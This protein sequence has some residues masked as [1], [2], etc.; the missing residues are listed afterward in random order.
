VSFGERLAEFS[1]RFTARQKAVAGVAAVVVVAAA[2]AGGVVAASGSPRHVAAPSGAPPPATPTTRRTGPE[3]RPAPRPPALNPLT[4]WGPVPGGAVVAVKIDDTGNGRPQRGVDQADIVYVEQAE[5][6]LTR[7]VAVFAT[8]K[9]VVEAV[10]SVRTSDPELLTQYGPIA[11]VASGGGGD[12]LP[13]L[14]RSILR[15]VIND[16]GGAGFGRDGARPVPYNLTSDLATASSTTRAARARSIGFTWS[17][18]LTGARSTLGARVDTVVG[19]TPVTFHW[20]GGISRYVRVIGG[21]PQSAADGRPIATPNV[22]VQYCQVTAHPGDVD[23]AGNVA[24]YTHSVGRGRV[25]VFRNGRRIDGTWSRPY[26][27]AGTVLRNGQGQPISL[28]PGGAWVILVANGA[29]LS[30]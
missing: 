24:Q 16:R 20:D 9:P 27:K 14:D 10:R 30:S 15:S 6:G 28:A 22:I 1:A 3:P 23:V 29:P 25:V 19:G 2:T 5:G 12:S 21:V 4:G 18:K 13:A 11:F 8:H 7:L 26:S 17:S